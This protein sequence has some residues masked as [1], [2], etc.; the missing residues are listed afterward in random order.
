MKKINKHEEFFFENAKGVICLNNY[1]FRKFLE[2]EDFFKNNPNDVG[3][4]D[5]IKKRDIFLKVV[6]DWEI[7][8]YVLDYIMDND[9]GVKAYN[10]MSGKASIFKRDY[11]S[12]IQT[13]E[14]KVI[15]DT[16]DTSYLFYENGVVEI[17][18]REAILKTYESFGLHIWEKQVI[19]RKYV[20]ADHHESEYR[21]F[22]WKISGGFDLTENS[23]EQEKKRYNLCVDRYNTFQTV[24]GYLLHSYNDG[25]EN[26]AIILNDEVI[27]DDPNGRS[28]KGLFWNA[29]GQLKNTQSLNGKAF[30]FNSPFPYQSVKIDCQLLVFDDVKKGFV[31]D[32]LFSIITEGIEITYKGKDTIKVP[33]KDSPKMLITTNYAIKGTGDSNEDRR[34]EVELSSFFSARNKPKDFFG[35]MLFSDWNDDEWARFDSYMIECLKKYLD[36]G[37]VPYESISLPYKKLEAGMSKELFDYI[38]EASKNEW[39]HSGDFYNGYINSISNRNFAK[40]KTFV[41]QHVK[42]Y[43]EFFG[44]KH[45]SITSNNVVKFMIIEEGIETKET[46]ETPF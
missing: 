31:F 30:D 44:F 33:L 13:K 28:G 9:L 15:R 42:K 21:T 23:T 11:L 16:K 35:H 5:L 19:K 4:F 34:F 12:M 37:L 20:E 40:T 2:S 1:E 6:Q 18:K 8:D 32:N 14:I 46:N 17:N 3:C 29:I 38:K 25:N 45:E 26:K 10:L 43:C 27:S 36:T 39:L 22:I 41:T 7:K 24:I